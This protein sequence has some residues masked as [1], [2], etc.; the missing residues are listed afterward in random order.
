MNN[1]TY[2]EYLKDR[3]A[4]KSKLNKVEARAPEA[5]KI[6][7]IE[8]PELKDDSVKQVESKLRQGE[9]YVPN[10]HADVLGFNAGPSNEEEEVEDRRPFRGGRGRGR[11]RGERGAPRGDRGAPRGERGAPRGNRGGARGGKRGG[12]K[13]DMNN[14]DFPTL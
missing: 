5:I 3:E 1:Y 13:L 9:S 8:K 10:A 12:N 2:D 7:N 14:D 6:K 4:Q 11:G